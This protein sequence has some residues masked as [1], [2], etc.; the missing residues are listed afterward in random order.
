[1]L[2]A[3]FAIQECKEFKYDV[4]ITYRSKDAEV[5]VKETLLPLL[6][7]NNLKYCVHDIHWEPG[8]P[9]N[10][11]MVESVYQS[12]MVL[13]LLSKNYMKSNYCKEEL[14]YAIY[15]NV[16]K[17]DRSLIVLKF[18][19]IDVKKI[20]KEI[21]NRTFI[22]TSWKCWKEKLVKALKTYRKTCEDVND[23]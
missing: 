2:P 14:Y 17:G 16:E 19:N 8:R 10:E 3:G 23:V 22:D 9:I 21:R 15:R 7:D 1:M 11:H 12:R 13:V 20:P 5:W 18:D 4:F 6:E